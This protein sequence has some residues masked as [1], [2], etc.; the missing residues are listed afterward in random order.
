MWQ[1]IRL[2]YYAQS[3]FISLVTAIP[4]FKTTLG[5]FQF[6]VIRFLNRFVSLTD[7]QQANLQ[8]TDPAPCEAWHTNTAFI[9]LLLLDL[10]KSINFAGRS[11]SFASCHVKS[12]SEDKDEYTAMM[13]S[14]WQG[15][16]EC[17]AWSSSKLGYKWTLISYLTE[18]VM[19]LHYKGQLSAN[20]HWVIRQKA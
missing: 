1:S 18:N 17:E 7:W 13:E 10:Q 8:S 19:H 6:L 14:C 5:S 20:Q 9:F 2:N 3:V 15:K 12:R 16:T 11:L 4:L